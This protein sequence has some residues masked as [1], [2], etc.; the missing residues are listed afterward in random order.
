MLL[1]NQTIHLGSQTNELGDAMPVV[2]VLEDRSRQLLVEVEERVQRREFALV[3]FVLVVVC[4]LLVEVARL[5]RFR[6]VKRP[7]HLKHLVYDVIL[8]TQ[9]YNE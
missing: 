5:D 7:V 6:E 9:L 3:Y 2:F 8:V 1:I 4:K